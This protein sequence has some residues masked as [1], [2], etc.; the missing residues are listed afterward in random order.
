MY[1]Y[2]Y[3]YIP[4]SEP[5]FYFLFILICKYPNNSRYDV[6]EIIG[7][8]IEKFFTVELEESKKEKVID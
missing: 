5:Y 4:M 6:Q 7:T 8:F 2:I 3:I 1:I